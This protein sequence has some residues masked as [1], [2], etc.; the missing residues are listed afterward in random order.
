MTKSSISISLALVSLSTGQDLNIQPNAG[1]NTFINAVHQDGGAILA[2]LRNGTQGR[3]PAASRSFQA[4]SPFDGFLINYGCW[5]FFDDG[6]FT[7]RAGR[8]KGGAV[9]AFDA[10]CRR[11]Q[12]AYR[13]SI[14]DAQDRN[15]ICHPWGQ[16]YAMI[17]PEIIH[18]STEDVATICASVTDTLCAQEACIIEANFLNELYQLIDDNMSMVDSFKHDSGFDVSQECVRTVEVHGDNECCGSFPERYP[19]R[20][21]VRECCDGLTSAPIGRC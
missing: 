18:K 1:A 2:H 14:M 6:D 19:Y 13:C 5:C 20:V 17:N 21:D 7:R 11:L 15:E 3:G 9:D 10:T 16:S 8:G 12:L 4:V